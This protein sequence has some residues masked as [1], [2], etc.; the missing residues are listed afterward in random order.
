[1]K[2]WKKSSQVDGGRWIRM[3]FW[4]DKKVLVTGG[5]GFIGS[6]LVERLLEHES[7]VRVV[8]RSE[9]PRNLISC[10]KKID[11]VRANLSKMK[12][13]A[14]VVHGMDAVFH[15]ASKVAGIKYNVAHPAEMF[16]ANTMLNLMML[17]A[18]R[19]ENVE[20]YLCT[21]SICVY[22]R[23]CKVPTPETEGFK[24]DPDPTVL[25][26]GWA[27]RIAELQARFYAEEYGMKIAI[28]R[29]TNA[30]GPRDDFSLE[31]SHV[32]P[33]LIRKVY[34]SNDVLTVWGSGNQTRS[35]IYVE[36]LARAMMEVTEKYAVA[37]PVN[38]GTDE[39][40][41]IKDLAHLI[42]ELSGKNLLIKFDLTKP[43]GQPRKFADISKA[44]EKLNWKPKFT[45]E[46]GI[47]KT[48]EWYKKFG[49]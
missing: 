17:E 33:A 30:Y 7:K 3:G 32:I 48:I 23:Y 15:L 35:F 18:S 34:E 4:A 21:S 40:V 37:D 20:R 44:K 47:K 6:H 27:K 22:P 2:F 25:G 10:L 11:Y 12:S 5:G 26:Y 39:E 19:I 38:I 43:E 29:P 36:D 24:D 31:T 9:K 41:T 16:R 14:E 8:G 1:M 46:E 28:I 45:L 49:R 13:C 42:L